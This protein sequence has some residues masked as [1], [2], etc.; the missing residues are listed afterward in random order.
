MTEEQTTRDEEELAALER[1]ER[2][3]QVVDNLHAWLD[4][5][6]DR[7]KQMVIMNRN[8]DHLNDELEYLV[9]DLRDA[10]PEFADIP[11]A[12]PYSARVAEQKA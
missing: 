11:N 3:V 1:Y 5:L 4:A 7:E 9:E 12:K 8:L 6:V 2:A 10:M